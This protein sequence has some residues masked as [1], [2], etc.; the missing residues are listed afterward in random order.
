[1]NTQQIKNYA[2]SAREKFLENINVIFDNYKINEKD[3]ENSNA[4][5]DI[6]ENSPPRDRI[7]HEIIMNHYEDIEEFKESMAYTWFNRFVALRYL[8]IHKF[9]GH[10]FRLLSNRNKNNKVVPEIT[11]NLS[12]V[13]HDFRVTQA[14]DPLE[15][16]QDIISSLIDDHS[17]G[18]EEEVY[19]FLILQ[20]CYFLS[21]PLG[22]MFAASGDVSYLFMPTDLLNSKLS[23]IAD[24]LVPY[25]TIICNSMSTLSPSICTKTP[26]VILSL[27]RRVTMPS[28]TLRAAIPTIP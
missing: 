5:Q 11:R 23:V 14:A 21:K 18:K 22:I 9:F 6:D 25:S 8:E 3:I 13:L 7:I 15:L 27:L 12:A 2:P 26:L 10:G 28:F 20:H 1:M 24:I 16:E 17:T 19:R 4:E